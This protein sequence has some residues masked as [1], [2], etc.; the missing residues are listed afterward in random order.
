MF[1]RVLQLIVLAAALVVASAASASAPTWVNVKLPDTSKRVTEPRVI[2]GPDD[3]RWVVTNLNAVSKTS[4]KDTFGTAVVFVSRDGGQTWQRT[5]ADPPQ[6]S[7]T[8]DTDIVAMHPVVAG[9]QPRIFASEL[10]DGGLNFPSG[11]TDDGGKTWTRSNGSTQLGD[12]DRQWF[13][14]GPDDKTTHKP[15]VYLLYH[16]LASGFAQHNMWVATS[17]DGGE[18]FGPPVPVTTPGSDAYADLQCADSGGP[19]NIA[20]NQRTGRIYVFFTTRGA[21]QAGGGDFGGCAAQPIEFNIVNATRVWVATSPD[22]TPGS[23]SDHL[24]VDDSKTGQ[25]VSMQLAYGALDTAGNVYVAYPESPNPYPHLAG[26]AVKLVTQQTDGT[27]DLTDTW[28]K[29]QTLVPANSGGSL[30][31]HMVAGAPGKI[32]VAYFRGKDIG[33]VDPASDPP[34]KG[35]AW[36]LHVLQSFDALSGDVH[37]ND[38]EVSPVVAYTWSAENMMGLCSDPNDPT[39]GVQNGVN[40]DRSTDVWGLALDSN[41]RLS[42]TWPVTK[43][44]NSANPNDAGTWV[45]TQTGGDTICA[46]QTGPPTAVNTPVS[47]GCHDKQAPSTRVAGVR[48]GRRSLRVHGIARDRGCS[49]GMRLVRVAVARK[50]KHR[51][52]RFLRGNGTL[53][54]PAACTPQHFLVAIGTAK[55]SLTVKGRF[56][57]G[58]YVVWSRAVD[59]AGNRERRGRHDHHTFFV[60]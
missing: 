5:E 36:Y 29:P 20:V 31:V 24:A 3:R 16:N 33:A 13:A 32:D 46:S 49:G 11:V 42:V 28:S 15:T 21:P 27:K 38:Y 54:K 53:G 59:N 2:V 12:Q 41:C 4:G 23:W 25:V 40:C 10:D 57:K 7:A 8:I 17:T 44:H 34:Q 30:L 55:W 1:R 51:R 60:H 6:E 37:A 19:S 9:G 43:P 50:V 35:T 26:A 47:A 22:G 39:G 14:V 56:A 52:C 18:T 58:R 45:S 48:A